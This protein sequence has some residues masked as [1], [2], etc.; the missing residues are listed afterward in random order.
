[1]LRQLLDLARE[2]AAL[3]RELA[4]ICQE[5]EALRRSLTD[6]PETRATCSCVDGSASGE[7]SEGRGLHD[8]EGLACHLRFLSLSGAIYVPP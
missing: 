4:Q 6:G 1:M 7:M 5:A 3:R 2:N 8:D